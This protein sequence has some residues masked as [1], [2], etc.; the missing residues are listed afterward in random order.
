MFVRWKRHK[1]EGSKGDLL[2]AVLV[3]C[4]RVGAKPP[5]KVVVYLRGIR[6]KGLEQ[7]YMRHWFW[8]FLDQR[9]QALDLDSEERARI[10]QALNERVPKSTEAELAVADRAR[11]ERLAR[12]ARREFEET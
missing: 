7:T 3:R 5:Q 8:H 1:R 2:T 9:L 12:Y 10:E 4:E 6:E 11:E